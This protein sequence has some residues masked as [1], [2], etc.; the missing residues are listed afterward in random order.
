MGQT[1]HKIAWEWLERKNKVF[2][3]ISCF[4]AF[5]LGLPEEILHTQVA[6]WWS[7][8]GSRLAYL[9]INDSLVPNML[10]PRFTGMLYPRGKEYPYPKVGFKAYF[11]S[12]LFNLTEAS[13]QMF[14]WFLMIDNW[15]ENGRA[16]IRYESTCM[17]VLFVTRC[18]RLILL[19]DSTWS[20]WT[21]APGQ[22]NWGLPTA[23]KRGC[24]RMLDV[25]YIC[26]W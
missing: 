17:S 8:D 18:V 14:P 20:P 7:P 24:I 3:I 1:F 4:V 21:A 25:L 11:Q 10:L 5:N 12:V 6:H 19:L 9:T 23:L 16:Q 22:L 13:A 26:C 2:R 15:D